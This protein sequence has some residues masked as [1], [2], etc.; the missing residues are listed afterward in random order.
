MTMLAY[1][2]VEH[3][4]FS[5]PQESA[6]VSIYLAARATSLRLNYDTAVT[7]ESFKTAECSGRGISPASGATT[8]R[9][10]S[11]WA[12][13]MANKTSFV[14]VTVPYVS[15]AVHYTGETWSD[16]LR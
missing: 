8:D 13:I 14:F 9:P 2:Y 1:M 7:M 3:D 11:P 12:G 4:K 5:N 6:R 15:P 10:W 16:V